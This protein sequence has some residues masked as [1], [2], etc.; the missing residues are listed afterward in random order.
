MKRSF[1]AGPGFAQAG[2]VS[3]VG[4]YGYGTPGF[5]MYPANFGGQMPMGFSVPT[6]PMGRPRRPPTEGSNKVCSFFNTDKGCAKGASCDFL[7]EPV[8]KRA[9]PCQFFAS[10]EGCKKGK[11]CDFLHSSD[12]LAQDQEASSSHV[13]NVFEQNEQSTEGGEQATGSNQENAASAKPAAT[14]AD[15]QVCAYFN[16]KFGCKKGL[17]CDFLH[18]KTAETIRPPA[19]APVD[20]PC[21]F[22]STPAGCRKGALCNF[23]H[24][25]FGGMA[26]VKTSREIKV[27]TYFSSPRGCI[28]G[29]QCGFQH[30]MPM[31]A[32]TPQVSNQ[33]HPMQMQVALPGTSHM[34]HHA[35]ANAA[36]FSQNNWDAFSQ[37]QAQQQVQAAPGAVNAYA[38][39]A[40]DTFQQ[41][42][43]QLLQ[44]QQ[45]QQAEFFQPLGGQAG[46]DYSAY[47]QS[48]GFAV[49]SGADARYL[50]QKP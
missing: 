36:M 18:E 20:R 11:C 41:P 33:M 2:Y 48:Q 8:K 46:A 1:T 5:G 24:P 38:Q 19:Q 21:D 44:Q 9:R 39:H 12:A 45:Q 26:V 50:Q 32:Y 23:Q 28:K 4:S 31:S 30:V 35:P 6:G 34:S 15:R 25:G 27:C 22:W 16:S 14:K 13:P 37:Q 7:H 17:T 3:Q 29:A 10:P 49:P 43:Q 42:Q 47:Y 40:Q